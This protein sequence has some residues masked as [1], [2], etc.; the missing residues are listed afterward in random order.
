[1]FLR[2]LYL[3]STS[4]YALGSC[5]DDVGVWADGANFTRGL[6]GVTSHSR[7]RVHLV[8]YSV[9]RTPASALRR[10]DS[11]LMQLFERLSPAC[12]RCFSMNVVC[13]YDNCLDR[14]CALNPRGAECFSCAREKCGAQFDLCSGLD[15]T[16]R[17]PAPV[18]DAGA[19]AA[20]VP[21]VAVAAPTPAPAEAAV[22]V[23]EVADE[24]WVILP[25][26]EGGSPK[27]SRQV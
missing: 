3:V 12:A 11:L 1:M 21:E 7:V 6:L 18:A 27:K 9:T 8:A 16:N 26:L 17:P 23:V 25:V 4:A 15:D 2:L 24:E 5:R 13:V 10:I 19:Q 20:P 14:G 22:L